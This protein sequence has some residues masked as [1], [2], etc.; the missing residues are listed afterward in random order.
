MTMTKPIM[1]D[2]PSPLM[3][4]AG[5]T[6]KGSKTN[7]S[8]FLKK[9]WGS[10]ENMKKSISF[11]GDDASVTSAAPSSNATFAPKRGM[12]ETIE[13]SPVSANP[14]RLSVLLGAMSEEARGK[15]M[16]NLQSQLAVPKNAGAGSESPEIQSSAPR[17]NNNMF[18]KR[19]PATSP[20][21]DRWN[22]NTEGSP[23]ERI[24][25]S[26]ADSM[27]SL[28]QRKVAANQMLGSGRNYSSGA[29]MTMISKQSALSSSKSHYALS[30]SKF[31]R[32]TSV[33]GMNKSVSFQEN[34]V[35][36]ITAIETCERELKN[37]VWYSDHEY[38][39]M[40]DNIKNA[41]RQ[42]KSGEFEENDNSTLHG[43]EAYIN[44]REMKEKRKEAIAA[45]MYE[46]ARQ[47]MKKI[48]SNAELLAEAYRTRFA[49]PTSQSYSDML[50][51][52]NE[53]KRSQI[54][55]SSSF[56]VSFSQ[57][58]SQMKNATWETEKRH[59][60]GDRAK[61][62]SAISQFR[63]KMMESVS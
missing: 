54:I 24:S 8:S 58:G 16:M 62:N 43:L 11:H 37:S 57:A 38:T 21:Y 55:K 56:T 3:A 44:R 41:L 30:T 45:V 33:S 15:L 10:R 7:L 60:E 53:K 17:M 1:E 19:T 5:S 28:L 29:S 39:G 23:K 27:K 34:P 42:Q 14:E 6:R 49:G 20:A 2:S 40:K 63:M 52:R 59:A 18:I 50:T 13:A 4:S 31:Q 22:E 36:S 61:A 32:K 47:R 51:N 48:P 35:Q 25:V 26:N 46:Q 12:L 9:T